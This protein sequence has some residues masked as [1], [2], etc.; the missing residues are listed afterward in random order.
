ML[1]KKCCPGWPT[2]FMY[3]KHKGSFR[4]RVWSPLSRMLRKHCTS[5]LKIALLMYLLEYDISCFYDI[6]LFNMIRYDL[7][8]IY[9]YN[10]KL[11]GADHQIKRDANL[12]CIILFIFTQNNIIV[13]DKLSVIHYHTIHYN[14]IQYHIKNNI[15]VRLVTEYIRK[16]AK[17]V[18]TIHL[19]HK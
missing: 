14:M 9:F 13:N 2:G 8:H 16:N 12:C 3:L 17:T 15:F 1:E 10:S 18:Y 5:L 19:Q 4:Y 6:V 11:P 7:I